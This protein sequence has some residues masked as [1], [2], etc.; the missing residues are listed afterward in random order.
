[1]AS[2]RTCSLRTQ[3]ALSAGKT[4]EQI[5]R[6]R[7]PQTN[8]FVIAAGGAP[9]SLRSKRNAVDVAGMAAGELLERRPTAS[10][11]VID[12]GHAVSGAS[13]APIDCGVNRSAGDRTHRGRMFECQ[14]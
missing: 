13:D 9:L 2:R 8:R 3:V 5:A 6:C 7:I 12:S 11:Q 1:M 4:L 10:V 14:F